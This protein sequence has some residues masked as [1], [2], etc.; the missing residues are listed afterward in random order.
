[1]K[2]LN[3]IKEKGGPLTA[4]ASAEHGEDLKSERRD[5]K[6]GEVFGRNFRGA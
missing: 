4:S 3:A 2:I 1:L 6:L 5:E